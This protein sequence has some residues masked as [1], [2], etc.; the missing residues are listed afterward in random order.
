MSTHKTKA[1]VKTKPTVKA[2]A[3]P[4]PKAKAKPAAPAPAAK[5]AAVKP[6]PTAVPVK[7]GVAAAKPA[8]APLAAAGKGA[9]KLPPPG[10]PVPAAK[11]ASIPGAPAKIPSPKSK[12][13]G[14]GG[15]SKKA[16]RRSTLYQ[17]RMPNGEFLTPGDLLLAGGPLS[18]EEVHYFFRGTVAA[19]HAIPNHGVLEILTKRGYPETDPAKG[20]LDKIATVFAK[21]FDS[22]S[23]EALPPSRVS[24]TQRRTFQ[25]VVDRAKQRRR[26]IGA[27]LR[28]LHLGATET[29]HM[30]SHGEASLHNLM[31]WSARIENLIEAEEPRNADYTQFHR[32]LDH[33]DNTTEALM[34]DV[35]LTL[36]RL[37]N[38]NAA[39]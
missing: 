35:E 5:K 21:R 2:K 38:R 37:R 23:I 31:E 26:E 14:R 27:F 10:K 33:L 30:D 13:G 28:G 4:Q 3:K 18:A 7:K 15:A 34:V 11:G 36:R 25:S 6:P 39:R 22:G 9:Q 8:P 29:S 17:R 16:S 1:K 19:E 20:E 32:G 12:P 24:L